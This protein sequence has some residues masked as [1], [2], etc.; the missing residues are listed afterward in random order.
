MLDRFD[1][2]VDAT[3]AIVA[4]CGSQSTNRAFYSEV[5]GFLGDLDGMARLPRRLRQD[6]LAFYVAQMHLGAIP[7]ENSG[8]TVYEAIKTVP[9]GTA[10]Q[11]SSRNERWQII[12]E[13]RAQ[14]LVG[15][16][17]LR[18]LQ[19]CLCDAASYLTQG[20]Q[21]C[22]LEL[23]GGI[24]STLAGAIIRHVRG[25]DFK[26]HGL[27]IC[28]P[29]REF[30]L[31]QRYINIAADF[32]SADCTMI[33]GTNLLPFSGWQEMSFDA[34]VEPSIF[35]AGCAQNTVLT[36]QVP[37]GALLINGNGG[38]VLFSDGPKGL[39]RQRAQPFISPSWMSQ[40]FSARCKAAQVDLRNSI[41]DRE[42]FTTGLCLDDRWTERELIRGK[43]IRRSHIFL[44]ETLPIVVAN[45]FDSHLENGS[46]KWMVKGYLNAFLPHEVLHRPRKV[47]YDG[48]YVRG[49]RA[50]AKALEKLLWDNRDY[51][52]YCGIDAGVLKGNLSDLAHGRADGE[53]ATISVI[54]FLRWLQDQRHVHA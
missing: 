41:S 28:Y 51:L 27:S 44:A 39:A 29:Y 7:L 54:T 38:D 15:N 40:E 18:D 12:Q 1:L 30:A 23:S 45:L 9:R 46:G 19:D 10:A 36:R 8:E 16:A 43:G 2:K 34:V 25:R 4:H 6:A 5:S 13:E 21:E 14:P 50:A 33:D 31:E 48:L 3:D 24:D 11:I 49:V 35:L 32:L 42:A 53:L 20:H 37:N 17:S 26:I 52:A 47:G 22:W